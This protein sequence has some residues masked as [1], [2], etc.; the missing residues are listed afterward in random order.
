MIYAR[1]AEHVFRVYRD[2]SRNATDPVD[3][4]R[5]A[6]EEDRAEEEGREA[7]APAEG[8]QSRQGAGRPS[9]IS[10]Q[11]PDGVRQVQ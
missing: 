11:L 1:L 3:R 10:V 6:E 4:T 9:Q 5:N 2:R 8:D 7:E